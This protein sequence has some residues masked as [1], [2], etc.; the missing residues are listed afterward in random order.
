MWTRWT[1]HLKRSC[2]QLSQT[3]EQRSWLARVRARSGADLDSEY[4]RLRVQDSDWRLSDL[5]A[6]YKLCPSYPSLL[7]F[8]GTLEEEALCCAAGERSSSRL[9]ALVWLHPVSKAP[10]CRAAQPLAGLS[11]SSIEA[12]RRLLLA[13]RAS[14]PSGL[15]LRIA[16]ARPKLNANANAMQG[17]GFESVAFLGG[18]AVAQLAFLDIDNIHVVRASL[19]KLRDA[20]VTAVT[21][22]SDGTYNIAGQTRGSGVGISY[23]S[24]SGSG[25]GSSSNSSS[26]NGASGGGSGGGGALSSLGVGVG[27]PTDHGGSSGDAQAVHISKWLQHVSSILRGAVGVADSLVSGHP[28]LVH[29]SDGW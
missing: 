15:P 3:G 8:P 23:G 9:P 18:P 17:K 16:D 27:A 24:S 25:A 21:G 10:L 29:C 28:V 11:G 6:S 4:R 14:C 13:I 1:K 20:L 19:N 22:F 7:V 12:D 2:S 5:N 26:G